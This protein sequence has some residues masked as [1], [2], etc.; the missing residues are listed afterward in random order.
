M[1]RSV[2]V[3][4][5]VESDSSSED[6]APVA[7]GF[8]KARDAAMV[9][10][11]LARETAKA[12]GKGQRAA[13]KARRSAV[14]AD[15]RSGTDYLPPEVLEQLPAAEAG[16]SSS[17][18]PE[19]SRSAAKRARKAAAREAREREARDGM[20]RVVR[21]SDDGHVD[22]A[23]LAS[24]DG[25]RT[26]APTRSDLRAFVDKQLY[27]GRNK[28][29]P[30][31]TIASLKVSHG[32]FGAAS[33]FATAPLQPKPDGGAGR[34]KRKQRDAPTAGTTST[35]EQMAARIMRKGKK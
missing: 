26:Q 20:P 17:E 16:P 27:G 24:D 34:A 30:A 11:A 1:K 28:R 2:H 32:R 14:T 13:E 21:Q 15:I 33:N 9:R 7:I 23:V 6:E 8:G 29:A 5:M 31:A 10:A 12:G 4:E 35:L 18:A 25:P 22:V 19:P 3:A